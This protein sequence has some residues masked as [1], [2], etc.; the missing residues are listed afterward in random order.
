MSFP[1]GIVRIVRRNL[2]VDD[3]LKSLKTAQEAKTVVKELTELLSRGGFRL[4]KW[5]SNDREVSESIPQSE[6]AASIVDLAL[7]EIP[8]ERTLGIQ[9]NVG[10]DKFCFKV[11]AKEKPLTRRGV[12]SVASSLYDPLGFLAPFTLSAK[13]ILQELCKK[14]LGRDERIGGEELKRWKDWLADLPRLLEIAVSRCFKPLGFG[15]VVRVQLHHFSDASQGAYGTASYLRLVD[16][17]GNIHCSFI[18]G[19]SLLA[20]LRSITIPR[21]ELSSCLLR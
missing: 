7:D 17:H 2:Y 15:D 14:K 4:T 12:L 11:V 1:P 16:V 3:C 20:P 9:W 8:V 19:K 13:M 18:I 21:L 10:A 6:R 5:I